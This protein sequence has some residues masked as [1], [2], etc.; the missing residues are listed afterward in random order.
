M[1]FC[2]CKVEMLL[3]KDWSLDKYVIHSKCRLPMKCGECINPAI[4]VK[5]G[6]PKCREHLEPPISRG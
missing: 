4:A 2:S 3:L 5:L 1:E 6:E